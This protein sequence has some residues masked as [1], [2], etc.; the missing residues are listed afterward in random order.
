LEYALRKAR[1]QKEDM[2][3][4]IIKTPLKYIAD[5]FDDVELY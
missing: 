1:L 4:A 2:F 3:D 5:M